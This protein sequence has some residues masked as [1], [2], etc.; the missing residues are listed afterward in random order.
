M[1]KRYGFCRKIAHMRLAVLDIGSNSIHLLVVDA[2]VGAPPLPATSHKEVLRLAEHLKEDGSITTYAKERLLQF[3]KEAIEIADD[4]GAEQILAFAT[5]AIRDAPNG[6]E[7]IEAIYKETG[8]TL[9][10][11]SGEDEARV[12]FLAARRWF[13]WSAGNLLLIDIGG[14]S[15]EIAAGRD[16]YPDAAVSVQL[17]AGRMYSKFMGG[18]DIATPD[19]IAALRRHARYLI[20]RVAGTV[21][22]VGKPENVV[23][24]SKTF[25]SLARLA[26]APPSADGIFVPRQLARKDLPGIIDELASRNAAQRA[27]L[28]GVSEARSGQVLAGAIVAEAAFTIFNIDTMN[29]SPWALREGIIMRKLDLL[30]SSETISRPTI[31][32]P[33]HDV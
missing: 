16:E 2:R 12:T 17:G 3:C 5:S 31:A 13:G 28:P 14:G 18:G 22:R 9:N 10:V 27:E 8:V 15:L 6:E 33:R 7:A 26:G 1:L 29:I 21:N 11:M 24:S 23:G 20:G 19:Q 4:Q 32:L 25:R 30:D